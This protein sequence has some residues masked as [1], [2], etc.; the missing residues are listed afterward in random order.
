MIV[1]VDE[2]SEYLIYMLM[3]LFLYVDLISE[4]IIG[5][6]LNVDGISEYVI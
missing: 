1:K 4:Y 3:W 5:V 6:I 2:L